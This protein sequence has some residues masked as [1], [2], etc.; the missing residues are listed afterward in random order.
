MNDLLKKLLEV[1][2]T[3]ATK[4]IYMSR[5]EDHFTL[6]AIDY[7]QLGKLR[8]QATH[9]VGK[10]ND[11]K[12]DDEQF[13]M[14]I[15]NAGVIEPSFSSPEVVTA[16]GTPED[17]IKKLLNPGEISK[18]SAAIMELSGFVDDEEEFEEIKN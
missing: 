8:E 12:L 6:Q 3:K 11:K 5:F 10:K 4:K 18:L 2:K 13:G 14:L 16:Y 15:I 17:A 9:F 1:G 7:E